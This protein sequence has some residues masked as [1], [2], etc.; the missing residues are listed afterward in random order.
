M[1]DIKYQMLSNTRRSHMVDGV[2]RGGR[3]I[4]FAVSGLSLSVGFGVIAGALTDSFIVGLAACGVALCVSAIALILQ[5]KEKPATG[6][7]MVQQDIDLIRVLLAEDD[8]PTLVTNFAGEMVASNSG[9]ALMGSE[10][11]R[12]IASLLD[13]QEYTSSRIAPIR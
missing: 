6:Q 3:L 5:L 10:R 2:G 13:V 4:G 7:A 12:P 8:V 1:S 9:Y 11:R